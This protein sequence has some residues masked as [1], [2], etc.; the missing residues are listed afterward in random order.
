MAKVDFVNLQLTIGSGG[1]IDSRT[2]PKKVDKLR[3]EG[4]TYRTKSGDP[5]QQKQLIFP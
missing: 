5:H 3:S 2:C 4:Q 1:I